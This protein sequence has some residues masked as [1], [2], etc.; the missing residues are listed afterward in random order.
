[1][2]KGPIPFFEL[3]GMFP[4]L[5]TGLSSTHLVLARIIS[6]FWKNDRWISPSEPVPGFASLTMEFCK[7]DLY[8]LSKIAAS[9]RVDEDCLPPN[10]FPASIVK[11][12]EAEVRMDTTATD[13]AQSLFIRVYY[14]LRLKNGT[15]KRRGKDKGGPPHKRAKV[16]EE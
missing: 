4:L 3:E 2:P 5:G 8:A 6:F 10:G 13:G 15:L 11:A 14:D 7:D 9:T 12:L 16:G 1:M